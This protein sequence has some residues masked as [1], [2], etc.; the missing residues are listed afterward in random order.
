MTLFQA[1]PDIGWRRTLWYVKL[2]FNN[3]FGD[4]N[5]DTDSEKRQP[6]PSSQPDGATLIGSQVEGW[7]DLHMPVLDIDFPCE[8][9]ESETPGHFHLFINK[10]I[11]WEEYER[12]LRALAQAGIV[13]YG[14]ARA[15]IKRKQSFVAIRPWKKKPLV[16]VAVF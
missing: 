15:S 3:H 16:E 10:P 14:Y 5:Y 2:S 8:L 12:L 13:E 7:P 4:A 1:R 9:R 6:I 11:L